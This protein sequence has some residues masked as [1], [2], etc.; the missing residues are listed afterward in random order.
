MKNAM[1]ATVVY[2]SSL[3]ELNMMIIGGSQACEVKRAKECTPSS[4]F[5]GSPLRVGGKS[6]KAHR[7]SSLAEP[8]SPIPVVLLLLLLL[9]LIMM[10]LSGT[11]RRGLEILGLL[12]AATSSGGAC[13]D[14]SELGEEAELAL[15][16]VVG[17][18]PEGPGEVLDVDTARNRS[19]RRRR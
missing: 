8:S 4:L 11:G 15:R 18:Q 6:E 9:L 14:G 5:G 16:Q 7:F 17:I 19:R 10:I 2:Y 13:D 12:A 3:V 1:H